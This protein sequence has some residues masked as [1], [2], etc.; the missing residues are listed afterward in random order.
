MG[1]ESIN[2]RMETCTRE[3]GISVS[4]MER[5][6]M[7][8][9]LVTHMKETINMGSHG[10]SDSMS[11]G[12]G[13]PTKGSSRKARNTEKDTGPRESHPSNAHSKEST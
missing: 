13:L 1:R 11:G 4:S 5:E 10:A 7:S 2:G 6:E 8:L 9:R 3:T 12:M